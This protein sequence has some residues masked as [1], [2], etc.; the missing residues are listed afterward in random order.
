MLAIRVAVIRVDQRTALG[1]AIA[2]K[3]Q[4]RLVHQLVT[5][6]IGLTEIVQEGLNLGGHQDLPVQPSLPP[7]AS[8]H[9]VNT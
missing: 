2:L 4:D 7:T 1:W 9:L 8:L 5:A 6:R 3:D